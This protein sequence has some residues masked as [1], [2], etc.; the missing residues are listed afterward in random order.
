MIRTPS[1]LSSVSAVDASLDALALSN[2][3]S[4]LDDRGRGAKVIYFTPRLFGVQAGFSYLWDRSRSGPLVTLVPDPLH[5][6]SN[7][8]TAF[9]AAVN[10]E[11]DISDVV[12]RGALAYYTDN[13]VGGIGDPV[14][15]NMGVQVGFG[16]FTL[17]GNYTRGDNM[18]HR[19]TYVN[20]SETNIWSAGV[21]WGNGPWL[22]GLN[23]ADG[24]DR[25]AG[26]NGDFSSVVGG[27]SYELGSGIKFGFGYQHDD[28]SPAIGTDAKG[29]AVFMETGLKF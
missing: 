23:Y 27:L 18:D 28:A 5:P 10:F 3:N 9:A 16:G 20:Q 7:G 26:V 6:A 15:Y 12:L 13:R 29:D 4:V 17:G 21:T 1:A 11:R 19:T 22:L 25:L 8:R 24:Q 14:G 2:V